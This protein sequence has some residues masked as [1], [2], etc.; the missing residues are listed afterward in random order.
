MISEEEGAI[1]VWLTLLSMCMISFILI[2]MDGVKVNNA[3]QI[4]KQIADLA[5]Y[6]CMAD[7]D[8]D[9]YENYNIYVME[10]SDTKT[11][12]LEYARACT[13]VN[14]SNKDKRL[15]S[16]SSDIMGLSVNNVAIYDVE[17]FNNRNLINQLNKN[18][19]IYKYIQDN[20]SS[21]KNLYIKGY[22]KRKY[23]YE[24]HKPF[25]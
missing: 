3:Q 16:D 2:V 8:I 25:R 17:H 6:S 9:V 10:E 23:L 20:F 12:Y 1:S 24:R 15:L 4:S 14:S 21:Y 22:M 13:S 18:H 11:K 5:T 19:N 7:Y